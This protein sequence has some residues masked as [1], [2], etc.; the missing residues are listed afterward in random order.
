MDFSLKQCHLSKVNGKWRSSC[1]HCH[2]SLEWQTGS[3]GYHS[4]HCYK[5]SS[6]TH[7]RWP[8][9]ALP[10]THLWWRWCARSAMSKC[11][12]EC[13]RLLIM[14][15]FFQAKII[16][17]SKFGHFFHW[18][19]IRTSPILPKNEKW[20]RNHSPFGL[21]SSVTAV[22][23]QPPLAQPCKLRRAWLELMWVKTGWS[24]LNWGSVKAATVWCRICSEY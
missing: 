23:G 11:L 14:I 10:G 17:M 16:Y 15:M 7:T 24:L 2:H 5:L 13:T 20:K 22:I 6:L 8:H 9:A 1:T 12:H 21:N 3:S 18:I 4:Q 19:Y